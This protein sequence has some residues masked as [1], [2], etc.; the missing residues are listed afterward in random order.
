VPPRL[1][2]ERRFRF[3]PRAVVLVTYEPERRELVPMGDF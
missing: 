1:V 3:R 2:L